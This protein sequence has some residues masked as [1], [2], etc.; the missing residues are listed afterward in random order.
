MN[1]S[2][3]FGL[4]IIVSQ[5]LIRHNVQLIILCNYLLH[6]LPLFIATFCMITFKNSIE[7]FNKNIL[8]IEWKN[9]F[10]FLISIFETS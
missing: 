10:P 3:F 7:H 1:Y 9:F 6:L 8:W 2:A 5:E 4:K